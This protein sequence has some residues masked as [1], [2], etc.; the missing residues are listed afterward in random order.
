MKRKP[1]DSLFRQIA[2]ANAVLL[3]VN[4]YFR[5]GTPMCF[6][7]AT[8]LE[9]P[10]L[11]TFLELIL[12]PAYSR[13]T[14]LAARRG[15]VFECLVEHAQSS[16]H[17]QPDIQRHPLFEQPKQSLDCTPDGESTRGT[18]TKTAFRDMLQNRNTWVFPYGST[19]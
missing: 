9:T 16:A 8:Y 3:L 2:E 6:Y 18:C 15:G 7:F 12:R 13:A 5:K 4:R 19:C 10:F 17:A 14:V 11:C 1:L